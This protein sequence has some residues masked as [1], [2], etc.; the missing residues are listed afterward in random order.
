MGMH[1]GVEV[2]NQICIMFGILDAID[3]EGSNWNHKTVV[4][5]TGHGILDEHR[6]L[7]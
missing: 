5:K 4:T 6:F 3:A 1:K 7:K 2:S